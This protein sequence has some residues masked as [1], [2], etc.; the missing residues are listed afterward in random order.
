MQNFNTIRSLNR[1]HLCVL[2]S[3]ISVCEQMLFLSRRGQVGNDTAFFGAALSA[4]PTHVLVH[5]G[6]PG[7]RKP[8]TVFMVMG[9]LDS[10]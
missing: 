2:T 3:F 10:N 4:F 9:L 6:I 8:G 1:T 5:Q 7:G